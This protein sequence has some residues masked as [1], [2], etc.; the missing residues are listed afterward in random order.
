MKAAYPKLEFYPVFGSFFCY[1]WHR[2]NY[3]S[4]SSERRDYTLETGGSSFTFWTTL[5]YEEFE[6][7]KE[8]RWNW[9]GKT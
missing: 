7:Q 6:I 9:R 1:R 4:I 3:V 2:V 5:I 8:W